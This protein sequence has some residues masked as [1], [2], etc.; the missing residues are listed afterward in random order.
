MSHV[1]QGPDR[2]PLM[3]SRFLKVIPSDTLEAT[4]HFELQHATRDAGGANFAQPAAPSGGAATPG[5]SPSPRPLPSP[6]PPARPEEVPYGRVGSAL[7]VWKQ[8]AEKKRADAEKKA[9]K[10][11]AKAAQAAQPTGAAYREAV[12]KRAR[13]VPKS[14]GTLASH[15]ARA[16]GGAV[17]A[18]PA[19]GDVRGRGHGAPRVE[20]GGAAPSSSLGA[21]PARKKRSVVV[22]EDE[23][24]DFA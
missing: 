23:E 9:A 24:D 2:V 20:G 7:D 17:E 15:Q 12:A 10:A 3:A 13:P 11:A 16:G 14:L 22:L 21:A 4:S 19:A 6:A 5:P 18:W 8:Q 1:M